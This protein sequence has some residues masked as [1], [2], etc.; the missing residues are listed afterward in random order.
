MK[1]RFKNTTGYLMLLNILSQL[2]A[3]VRESIFAY[4]YGTSMQADAYIMASQI[5]ITLFAI[6][7]TSI[8][9]VILPLYSKK[10]EENCRMKADGFLSS[11]IVVFEFIC[12]ACVCVSLTFAEEIVLIFAP[13]FSDEQRWITVR[14]VR[15]LFPTVLLSLLI[16]LLTV[17]YNIERK[18]AYPQTVALLQNLSIIIAMILFARLIDVKAAVWG[19]I[20]GIILNAICLIVPCNNIFKIKLEIV[21]LWQDIKHVVVKVLPVALGVGIDEINRIIDR[22]IASGLDTGS[23]TSLNY[24]SKLSVVFSALVVSVI[25]TVSFQKM[26]ELYAQMQYKKQAE[27]LLKYLRIVIYILAPISIG[28]LIFREEIIEIVFAR[29]AFTENSV[30]ITSKVFFYYAIGI[31]AIAVREILSKYYFSC[32]D[33]KTPVI[34]STI[35]VVINIALNILLSRYMGAAGLALSTTISYCVVCIA[36]VINLLQRHHYFSIKKIVIPCL[37][38]LLGSIIMGG[39]ILI[40]SSLISLNNTWLVL[41][42]GTSVGAIVYLLTIYIFAKDELKNIILVFIQKA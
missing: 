42:L 8:N 34:N 38:A 33:T 30:S 40:A 28:S 23:I 19:T 14:Y 27:E 1:Q 41:L 36:L 4:Y 29:G 26:S 39:V 12:V 37:P 3:F 35:G 13:S 6:V 5:P 24:A 21:S 25:S 20:I 31:V 10:K 15:M 18:F 32:G 2:I 16:S 9:T 17:R 11:F 22:A 7:N